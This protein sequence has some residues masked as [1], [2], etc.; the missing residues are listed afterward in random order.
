[1]GQTRKANRGDRPAAADPPQL[2]LPTVR[3]SNVF[4]FR[5]RAMIR[6]LFL[7]QAWA[8][9]FG[10]ASCATATTSKASPGSPAFLTSIAE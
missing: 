4:V 3:H 5:C 1:L 10:E 6:M 9:T 7:A 2:S 8:A